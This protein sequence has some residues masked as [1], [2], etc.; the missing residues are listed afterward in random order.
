MSRRENVGARRRSPPVVLLAAIPVLLA[1]VSIPAGVS[2]LVNPTSMG[3]LV[4]PIL[5]RDI[6]FIHDMLPIGIWLVTVYGILPI[7]VALGVW[8]M[9][10][11]ASYLSTLLGATVVIWIGAE[12]VMFYS[13]GF[14]WFYPLIGGAGLAIL[15]LSLLPTVKLS[16]RG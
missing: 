16:L 11:W 9:K 13:L 8:R 2:M 4:L 3:E 5:T 7:V 15:M 6:P 10:G 1:V 14:T 12:L